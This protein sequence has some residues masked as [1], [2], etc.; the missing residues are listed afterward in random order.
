MLE[1]LNIDPQQDLSFSNCPSFFE[2][3]TRNLLACLAL[4]HQ[5]SNARAMTTR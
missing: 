1:G 5:A 3:Q 4:H 2:E